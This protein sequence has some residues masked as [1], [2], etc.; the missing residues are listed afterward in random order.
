MN[1]YIFYTIE[2]NT[3]SPNESKEVDNCQVIG[4][5]EGNNPND[6]LSNLLDSN[7]WIIPAGF[8]AELF[9]CRQLMTE[10]LKHDIISI[11]EYLWND[12]K[13][14]YEECDNTGK[15]NHIFHVLKRVKSCYNN[16]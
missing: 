14:H 7:K 16:I 12:E 11:V 1:E 10:Q 4:I 6:A 15:R 3:I 5:S 13:R 9:I 8:N 2:G